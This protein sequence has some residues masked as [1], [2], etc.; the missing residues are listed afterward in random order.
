MLDD[1]EIKILLEHLSKNGYTGNAEN[2]KSTIK[3]VKVRREKILKNAASFLLKLGTLIEDESLKISKTN[4]DYLQNVFDEVETAASFD[5]V[6]MESGDYITPEPVIKLLRTATTF[7]LIGISDRRYHNPQN[8]KLSFYKIFG[9][10]EG[11]K[12]VYYGGESFNLN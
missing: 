7:E 2:L 9:G 5:N 10:F 4:K 3:T 1:K 8:G 6:M 11:G 12:E